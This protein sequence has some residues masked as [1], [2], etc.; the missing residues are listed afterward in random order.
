MMCEIKKSHR[1]QGPRGPKKKKSFHHSSRHM[2]TVRASYRRLWR[3]ANSTFHGDVFARTSARMELRNQFE[4]NRNA[5]PEACDDLLEAAQDAEDFLRNNI[6]QAKATDDNTFRVELEDP[7]V[8][9]KG[10]DAVGTDRNLDF[11]VV[12]SDDGSIPDQV[13]KHGGVVVS[14]DGGGKNTK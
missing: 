11:S 4:V 9:G 6:T 5:P 8:T 14:S 3:A 13:P 1:T 10:V 7:H 12:Q 2:A